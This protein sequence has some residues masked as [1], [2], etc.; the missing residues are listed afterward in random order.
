[1]QLAHSVVL[2]GSG[3]VRVQS[4]KY[5]VR[6]E[7]IQ[8]Q[9]EGKRGTA[10]TQ[11]LGA[12]CGAYGFLNS[13]LYWNTRSLADYG[14]L[15]SARQHPVWIG[16]RLERDDLMRK[17]VVLGVHT[18]RGINLEEF[19]KKFGMAVGDAFPTEVA[20]CVELGLL[21]LTS[22]SLEPSELGY[23]FGDEIGTMFYSPAV[24][25]KLAQLGVKYGMF[26]AD[27]RCA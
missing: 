13:T 7:K 12:G 19:H 16:Q 8:Q 27:D 20:V 25:A 2:A 9:T 11:L 21:H 6:R 23:F 1:M 14:R 17:S 15:A 26:F 10:R 18:S 3:Y 4:H 24:K 22:H 5:A